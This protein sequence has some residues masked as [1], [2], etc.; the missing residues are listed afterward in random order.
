MMNLKKAIVYTCAMATALGVIGQAKAKVPDQKKRRFEPIYDSRPQNN[1]VRLTEQ[2]NRTFRGQNTL[3]V[4]QLL[5]I[6]AQHRGM[7]LEK[8][9]LVG[10]TAAGRG[11]AT[12]LVNGYQVDTQQVGKFEGR[13]VLFPNPNENIMGREVNTIQLKLNGRFHVSKLIAVLSGSSNTGRPQQRV[14]VFS[15]MIQ[16]NYRGQS[17]LAVRKLLGLGQAH[18]GKKITKVIMKAESARG[19]GQAKLMINGMQVGMSQTVGKWIDT[20]KFDIP[21]YAQE[22]GDEIRTLQIQLNG[23]IYVQ[24]LKAH[25]KGQASNN[26]GGGWGQPD[27][28]RHEQLSARPFQNV[29]AQSSLSLAK[30]VNASY[31]EG[32][33][34]VSSVTIK[35][36]A[37]VRGEIQLCTV[38]R[39]QT[40]T[41]RK[42]VRG[43]T[44]AFFTLNGMHKLQDIRVKTKGGMTLQTIKVML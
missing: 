38:G 3:H 37:S 29:Y 24:S 20:L 6:N 18:K 27:P 23:N 9:V 26:N 33:K 25:V 40:C 28:I 13:T 14:Q 8:I 34:A 10:S 17:T 21:S 36:N 39:F 30:L 44:R 2:M 4:K 16:Q 35:A 22:L 5:H 41:Q 11:K 15:E 32:T 1:Q 19:Q 7:T 12:L 43:T 31:S 42:I